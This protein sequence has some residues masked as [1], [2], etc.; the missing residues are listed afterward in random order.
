MPRPWKQSR[1]REK[2]LGVSPPVV[3]FESA[4][5]P[6]AGKSK[7]GRCAGPSFSQSSENIFQPI[8]ALVRDQ[9]I[10]IRTTAYGRVSQPRVLLHGEGNGFSVK[11]AGWAP[12]GPELSPEPRSSRAR[13][14]PQNEED[15]AEF[16]W[17][18]DL[19]I[20][21]SNLGYHVGT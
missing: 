4:P 5:V 3:N 2:T 7:A 13:C 10:T 1:R 19:V 17:S 8:E 14:L 20:G 9:L 21:D 6:F 11:E 18:A 16:P 15:L 12:P